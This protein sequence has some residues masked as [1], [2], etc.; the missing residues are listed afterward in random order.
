MAC[1]FLLHGI[2]HAQVFHLVI[3]AN[4]SGATVKLKE[5]ACHY[6]IEQCLDLSQEFRESIFFSAVHKIP[7]NFTGFFMYSIEKCI[8]QQG[9]NH[10]SLCLWKSLCP[11]CACHSQSLQQ[12]FFLSEMIFPSIIFHGLLFSSRKQSCSWLFY[13]LSN[14]ILTHLRFRS[15]YFGG[16]STFPRAF[17]AGVDNSLVLDLRYN[18]NRFHMPHLG[19]IP[20]KSWTLNNYASA[21]GYTRNN[22][23]ANCPIRFDFLKWVCKGPCTALFSRYEC[24]QCKKSLIWKDVTKRQITVKSWVLSLM[25]SARVCVGFFARQRWTATM[26]M[27]VCVCACAL[28]WTGVGLSVL[29]IHCNAD[30]DNVATEDWMK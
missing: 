2:L 4:N 25:R 8:L 14:F 22:W 24:V 12:F 1:L 23:A 16:F 19:I 30:Q 6:E 5:K 29:E 18:S 27:C 17:F 20:F 7:L 13:S 3:T 28:R 21:H 11:V 9:I 10:K 15:L 26:W